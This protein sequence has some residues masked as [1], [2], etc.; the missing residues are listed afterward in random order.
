MKRILLSLLA[1]FLPWVIFLMEGKPG[2]CIGAM[3][4]QLTVIG[5]LPMTIVAWKHRANLL[6]AP[7]SKTSHVPEETE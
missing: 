1:L 3:A 6:P 7:K 5:W 4:L 2:L